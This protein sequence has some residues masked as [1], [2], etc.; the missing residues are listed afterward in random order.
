[1]IRKNKQ[2]LIVAI[3]AVLFLLFVWMIVS[4]MKTDPTC[5]DGKK[6]Q[7]EEQ[8]D[9]GG[10]C[11]KCPEE[12]IGKDLIVQNEH[13]VYGG[14]NKYDVVAQINN[15]NILYGG[16][17]VYYTVEILDDNGTV[18]GSVSDETFIL[19][20]ETKYLV[21]IG[22]ETDKKPTKL[23][24][25]INNVEWVKFTEFDSPQILVK[26]QK[27][28]FVQNGTN[29]AEAFG[30]VSNDSVYD[31]NNVT[32]YV[33]LEDER[34]IPVAVN[35][36]EM[37]TLDSGAKRDFRLIWPHKFPG[38]IKTAQM[39]AETNTFDSLNFMKKYLPGGRY[40]EMTNE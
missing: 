39:Q 21:E 33:I 17:K 30:L 4:M 31:F 27:F 2:M 26:N 38:N 24:V 35:S 14:E 6:N 25:S 28:G 8:I 36:T 5:F 32:I 3:Y 13:L 16:E 20:N 9:C 1:M 34:G 23:K 22:L 37:R 18:L 10:V 11:T 40:Q 15:P 29:Y 12:L 7:N 19:P